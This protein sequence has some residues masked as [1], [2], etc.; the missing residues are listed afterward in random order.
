[1]T[2]FGRRTVAAVIGVVL[3]ILASACSGTSD[4][5]TPSRTTLTV[6][7][8]SSLTDALPIV[9]DA[10]TAEHPG[11]D[12]RFS[13]AGSQDL[14]AQV[15]AGSP[16]DVVALAGTSALKPIAKQ[17]GTPTNF[18]TNRLTIVVPAGNPGGVRSLAD[19]ADVRVSLAAP[20]VPAG[21]Y[22]REALDNAGVQVDPVSEEP[23]VKSVVTRVT[24][25]GADAGIVYVT[26]AKA[27]GTALDEIAIPAAVNV[28][29]TYPAAAVLDSSQ[30]SEAEAF[31]RFL[32]TPT[33]QRV[34]RTAGFGPPPDE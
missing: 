20:E 4:G 15:A 32:R 24:V 19:L 6:L 22:A 26:D 29:A 28:T 1:M 10:F 23:D 2:S 21:Q 25:G 17:V 30:E 18:A 7:A 5:A 16:A 8:A 31:V 14:V 11:V 9:G 34:L 27:A 3:A 12:V 33:V 13:F